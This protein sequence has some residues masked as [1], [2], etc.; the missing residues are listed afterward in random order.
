MFVSYYDH[1]GEKFSCSWKKVGFACLQLRANERRRLLSESFNIFIRIHQFNCRCMVNNTVGAMILSAF[2][3]KL[4][5]QGVK[6]ETKIPFCV[7]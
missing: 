6:L 2:Q 1:G 7:N 5:L 4:M 3:A